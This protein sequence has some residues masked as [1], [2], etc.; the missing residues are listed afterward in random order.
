[1]SDTTKAPPPPKPAGLASLT[2]NVQ[3]PWFVGH[4]VVLFGGFFYTLGAIRIFKSPGF[5]LFWY[6]LAYVAA[7]ATFGLTL[8]E[9][10][11]KKPP[12]AAQLAQDDNVHYL[13][14]A[15]LWLVSKPSVLTLVPF[16]IFSL[17]HVVTFTRTNVLPAMGKSS[18]AGLGGQLKT[19]ATTYNERL[20]AMA[21]H[22]ELILLFTMLP[23]ALTFKKAALFPF[24]FYL[25]FTK[26]R[27]DQSF[28]MRQSVKHWEARVDQLMSN[29]NVPPPVKQGW[30]QFKQYLAKGLSVVSF[31]KPTPTPAAKAS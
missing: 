24:I 22:V 21:S 14:V 18:D 20:L 8:K 26:I 7:M 5:P 13:L 23:S 29:P 10:Y 2:K 28:H 6:R 19:F 3:F 17:F 1:M 4:V 30:I 15:L 12:A 27:H 16:M 31:K 9:S 25:I 11:M